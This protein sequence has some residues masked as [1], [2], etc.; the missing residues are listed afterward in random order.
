M[1][2]L[3]S[4]VVGLKL[5]PWAAPALNAGAI[6]VRIHNNDDLE[7]LTQMVLEEALALAAMPEAGGNATVLIGAPH[8]LDDF[9][10]FL[11]LTGVVEGLIDDLGLR[12]KVQLASF[13]PQ[14][15]VRKTSGHERIGL[16]MNV[17]HIQPIVCETNIFW[18][19][20]PTQFADSTPETDVENHTNRSPMPILHLLREIEVSN[21]SA[22]HCQNLAGSRR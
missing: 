9:D 12:G 19:P 10:D 21:N 15:K 5:C 13:H 20:E 11:Q 22:A 14:Y 8:A 6:R 18:P 1:A 7:A 4:V 3:R 16:H 2:W 17:G